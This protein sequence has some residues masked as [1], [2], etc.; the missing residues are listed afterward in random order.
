MFNPIKTE[1]HTFLSLIQ[2]WSLLHSSTRSSSSSVDIGKR[3]AS[4]I[5]SSACCEYLNISWGTILPVTHSRFP[6]RS[7]PPSLKTVQSPPPVWTFAQPIVRPVEAPPRYPRHTVSAFPPIVHV[8]C[9]LCTLPAQLVL[10]SSHTQ[11]D[12]PSL[13]FFRMYVHLPM[14]AKTHRPIA[15][16]VAAHTRARCASG[17]TW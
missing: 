7:P 9:I 14:T 5:F 1:H 17:T 13:H 2:S 6:L 10:F 16:G 15:S 4:R 3:S 8:A 12:A 11:S